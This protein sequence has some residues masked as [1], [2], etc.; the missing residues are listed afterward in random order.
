MARS[1][2]KR[3]PKMVLKLP[4]LEQS[5]S[6]VLNSL[7]S[8]SSKRSYDH[9]NREFIGWYCSEP[10]LASNKTVTRYRPKTKKLLTSKFF[11]YITIDYVYLPYI[12]VDVLRTFPVVRKN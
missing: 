7:T 10:R 9:A 1:K 6:A 3:A 12:W 11:R 2:R 8:A 5:K 4:D